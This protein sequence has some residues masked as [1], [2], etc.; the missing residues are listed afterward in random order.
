[1]EPKSFV[2]FV[3]SKTQI[4][5]KKILFFFIAVISAVSINAQVGTTAID[6]TVTDIDGNEISLYADI[7]DQGYVAILDCSATWCGPCWAMHDSHTLEDIHQAYGPNGTDQVRV[8]FYEA[9]PSTTQADL[10]GTGPSTQGDWITG[11]TFPIVN[12]SP[13]QLSGGD[14][15]PLGFPTI[16][17]IRPSDGMI[18]AD[19]WNQTTFDSFVAAVNAVDTGVTLGLVNVS[20]ANAQNADVNIYPNPSSDVATVNLSGFEGKVTVQVFDLL[21][22]EVISFTST[23]L[24]EMIDL[25]SLEEG[26]YV[27]KA[28]NGASEVTK[29]ISVIR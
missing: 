6:F 4:K 13:L 22:K 1:M 5:M 12:E 8:V 24:K 25:T 7:L 10:E 21:G 26:H 29:R 15:W 19:P 16:S 2:I 9:D 20:E 3:K 11:V 23:S 28:A 17:I 14:Y 18:V 27:V